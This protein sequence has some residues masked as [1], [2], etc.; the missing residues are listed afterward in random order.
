[1]VWSCFWHPWSSCRLHC[2]AQGLLGGAE[3]VDEEIMG[4]SLKQSL[5]NTGGSWLII[6]KLLL[7]KPLGQVSRWGSC[8]GWGSW[9]CPYPILQGAALLPPLLL[10]SKGSGCAF[11]LPA[12]KEVIYFFS[13]SVKTTGAWWPLVQGSP[14]FSA[15]S[16]RVKAIRLLH[17]DR[18]FA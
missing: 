13:I 9:S 10:L 12:N 2:G 7:P 4:F 8:G 1:M 11:L 3:G 16:L 17:L 18:S 14:I 15:S 5:G 6:P